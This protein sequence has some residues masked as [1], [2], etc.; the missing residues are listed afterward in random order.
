MSDV[1]F[2]EVEGER[3]AQWTSYSVDS[4]LMTPADGFVFEV[5]VP[6]DDVSL[7]RRL[8]TLLAPGNEVKIYVG[9]DVGTGPRDRFAQM[10]GI[11]DD[12]RLSASRE[13]G[14]VITI[15]GRDLAGHLV[16]ASVELDIDVSPNMRLVDLVTAA[17]EPY[18]ITVVTDSYGAQ[19]ALQAA[20][21]SP[22]TAARRAGVPSRRYSLTAQEEA[23]RTGRAID[24]V[25]G[26]SSDTS[27]GARQARS[28][29]R[30]GYAN[31][32]GPSDVE[33]LTVKD[34]RP[35]VGETVWAFIE[36]HC[37]RLG[38]LL[39]FSPLGRL[40]LSAP[41]YDQTPRYKA[42]RRYTN[43]PG[44]DNNVLSGTLGES[45][46]DRHSKVV[47]YGRGNVR[48]SERAPIKGEAVDDTWPSALPKPLYLQDT[49]IKTSA[50]AAR[51]ALRELMRNKQ[52]A[53]QLQY[54]LPDHGQAG[55]LYAIDSTLR[56]IDEP[57]DIDGTFYITK[58]T[59]KKD[60]ENG[61]TTEIRAVPLRS[62]VY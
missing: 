44:D 27:I 57:L 9:D 4:D 2:I 17:V 61:T 55:Y 3:I 30:S 6:G 38:V 8:L 18:G 41:Q 26:A 16:D 50:E 46:G 62:L 13:D 29:A 33:R 47:V 32:M 1:A 19:R 48:S 56:V 7:S 21:T 49:S 22:A 34:A 51:R 31:V 23:S 5:Q 52:D 20:R 12:R 53:Y 58:R 28:A 40:I 42:V 43:E 59:F 36:R 45:I 11:I 37:T 10:V 25:T 24:D 39:W 35:Q 54:T 60:R 14:T 15:E